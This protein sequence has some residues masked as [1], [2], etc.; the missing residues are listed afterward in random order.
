MSN[1]EHVTVVQT[2]QDSICET[3]QITHNGTIPA[4]FLNYLENHK[5]CGKCT[6]HKMCPPFFSKIVIRNIFRPDKYLASYAGNVRKN[7]RS[8]CNVLVIGL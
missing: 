6:G 4:I 2:S 8:S 1:V 7:A 5:T 3:K